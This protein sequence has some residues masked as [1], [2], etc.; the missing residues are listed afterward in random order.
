MEFLNVLAA[1][2][3]SYAFGAL[4]YMMLAKPWMDAAG[5]EIGDNGKPKGS[6]PAP[7]VIAFVSCLLVAGMMR[8]ILNSSGVVTVP[9]GLISGFGIGLFLSTPWLA[10][11]YAFGSRPFR[12]TLIDGGYA[13][14]GSAIM[15]FV[16]TLF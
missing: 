13:T 16:L 5:V 8:H 4:W 3:A 2:L 11:C 9:G 10:T 6:S 15:G 1:A 7:Y 14:L 12:L